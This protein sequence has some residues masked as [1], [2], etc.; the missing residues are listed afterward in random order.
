MKVDI[1]DFDL[2]NDLIAKKSANPKDSSRMLLVNRNSIS[3]SNI[4]N[5][6]D[7][8]D[9]GDLFVINNTRVLSSRLSGRIKNYSV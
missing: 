5:L 7:L 4:N 1:F 2:P 6:P 9:A 8:F 3:D